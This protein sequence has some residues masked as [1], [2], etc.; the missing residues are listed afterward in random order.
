MQTFSAQTHD[1]LPRPPAQIE[2]DAS[3]AAAPSHLCQPV[4]PS[5]CTCLGLLCSS[6]QRKISVPI[7]S[8]A[9]PPVPKFSLLPSSKLQVSEHSNQAPSPVT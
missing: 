8:R 7:V 1:Q 9:P 3:E 6:K 5:F 4:L 2:L